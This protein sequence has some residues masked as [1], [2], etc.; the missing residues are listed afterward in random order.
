MTAP[1]FILQL[2]VK[3]ASTTATTNDFL[4]GFTYFNDLKERLSRPG[5][6]PFYFRIANLVVAV[7][8]I[9]IGIVFFTWSSFTRIM[10]G[11][12]E[13]LFGIWIIMLEVAEMA[14]LKKL[15]E[16]MFTWR[17]RGLFYIF[18]GCLTL[19]TKAIGW[20]F[21]AVITGVGAVYVFLSFTTKKNESYIEDAPQTQ[22]GGSA[23]YN[24]STAGYAGNTQHGGQNPYGSQGAYGQTGVAN[25][26]ATHI[27]QSDYLHNPI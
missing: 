5:G 9:I 12:Y 18:I 20:V 14:W 19:G 3:G 2:T 10:L 27:G 7:L 11:I 6:P 22:A 4:M 26:S 21:G 15:V 24:S 16:F 13:I 8:M 17:G 1:L 25:P 23:M